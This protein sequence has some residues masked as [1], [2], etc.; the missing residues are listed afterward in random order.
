MRIA[1]IS[2]SHGELPAA[3]HARL[4]GCDSILHL[5]DLGP[6]RLLTELAVMAPV[7]A[8]MGNT[9]AAGQTD[10]PARRRLTLAG[11]SV[12]LRHEPWSPQELAAG[13]GLYLHGHIHHPRIERHGEAWICCPGA[14]T[15]PRSSEAAYGILELDTRRLSITIHALADGRRLQGEEWPRN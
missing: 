8:V 5:G 6:L 2:D 4:E 15:R 12:H 9:D 10:L 14:L 1:M 11:L 7:H 3:L 13:P